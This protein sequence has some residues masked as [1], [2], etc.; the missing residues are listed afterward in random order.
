MFPIKQ[1]LNLSVINMITGITESKISTKY[2]SGKY[3]RNLKVEVKWSEKKLALKFA[4]V[5]ISMA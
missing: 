3:E 2:M 4:L 5:K 1:D